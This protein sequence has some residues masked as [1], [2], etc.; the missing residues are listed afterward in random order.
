[1]I[2]QNIELP[3]DDICDKYKLYFHAEENVYYEEGRLTFDK[4]GV[5]S[6][7]TYFNGVSIDKWN[8]YTNVGRITARINIKGKFKVTASYVFR[9][10]PVDIRRFTTYRTVVECDT[11]QE[12]EIPMPENGTGMLYF[13]LEA[14]ED[15]GQFTG[16]YYHVDNAESSIR[17]VK[18]GLG[19]CTFKREKFIEKNI[20]LLNENVF[21]NKNCILNGHLEVYISDNGKTLDK[22]KLSNKH[23]HI[24]D[25]KNTGGAGG[26]TRTMMEMTK[27]GN[28]DG[29]THVLV[30]DDDILLDTEALV[31]TY[32]ILTIIKDEYVDAFI[33]G[34]ML[35]NDLMDIQVEAG[36]S[37][38]AGKLISYKGGLPLGE[39]EPCLY[40]ETE[41]RYEFNAWWYCCFPIGVVR[42][43]N[44]PLP[45]FIRGDDL[46][47]G[48]RNMKTL[49]LMNG[50]CV[51]HEPFE[52]KYS[53]FL[54][55]YIIRNKLIDNSF[56]C[57][58]YGK[59]DLIKDILFSTARESML[60]RYKNV[61]LF[62]RG[63]NDYLQ[64]PDYLFKADGEQLHKDIM[65]A[66]YRAV[67]VEELGTK[68]YLRDYEEYKG[69]DD[70][71]LGKVVR[72]LTLNGHLIPSFTKQRTVSM[73]GVLTANVF[74]AEQVLYY[75][76]I[77]NKGFLAVKDTK[78]FF[79][80][81]KEAF[82]TI[83]A[84][85]TKYD[86]AKHQYRTKGKKLRT[87]K[88]WNKYLG[89]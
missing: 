38:N 58:Q 23:V 69:R 85:M 25:N 70:G 56:H 5:C 87:R 3:V 61:K 83:L 22:E 10:S 6:F 17:N 63:V 68:F 54:E 28:P 77:A 11:L 27:D 67:P 29:I 21:D 82:K 39:T 4:T 45:I 75:D 48:L 7:D 62:L 18:I 36:A 42:D 16:G 51:W 44:L 79:D 84:V 1:M 8:K 9:V 80:C 86:Y 15:G 26:F 49:I 31:K 20:R 64:G 13:T 73:S 40:N 66:G 2:L 55:Y 76:I 47:Y 34:A 37:W 59:L 71:K 74:G 32:R 57:P 89:L 88:F 12:I 35:R 52:N 24:F 50:I 78:E 33:G 43:D 53:S 81:W 19:I 30:M 46:E 14:L 72:F 60:Y 41:E 65:A